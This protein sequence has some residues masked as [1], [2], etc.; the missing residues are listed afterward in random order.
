MASDEGHSYR[1]QVSYHIPAL[2]G[3][4]RQEDKPGTQEYEHRHLGEQFTAK[5]SGYGKEEYQQDY[6]GEHQRVC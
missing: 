5:P 3:K 4:N 2:H 6:T 1:Y